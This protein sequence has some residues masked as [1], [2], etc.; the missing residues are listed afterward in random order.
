MN[1]QYQTALAITAAA[2]MSMGGIAQAESQTPYTDLDRNGDGKISKVEA[3]TDQ[4]LASKFNDLD[5]DSDGLLEWGEF[6]RFEEMKKNAEQ[7]PVDNA[8][9]GANN[10][11]DDSLKEPAPDLEE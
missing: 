2:L 5:V 1:K 7:A 8:L 3:R 11:T 9:P 10:S 4:E 6:A